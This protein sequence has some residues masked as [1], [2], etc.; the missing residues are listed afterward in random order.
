M[1]LFNQGG[2]IG[3][4]V[5]AEDVPDFTAMIDMTFILLAFQLWRRSASFQRH[6]Y[7]TNVLIMIAGFALFGYQLT[8]V[9]VS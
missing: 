7:F 1:S 2:T 5:D 9:L 3:A 8:G 4:H 6:A